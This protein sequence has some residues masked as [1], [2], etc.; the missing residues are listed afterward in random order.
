MSQ[1]LFNG[2]GVIVAAQVLHITLALHGRTVLTRHDISPAFVIA[3]TL[4][5][6]QHCG[7]YCWSVTPGPKSAAMRALTRQEPSRNRWH[8]R[9]ECNES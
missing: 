8:Y 1:Q 7:F 6:L 2:L 5:L 4:A 9:T 3:G